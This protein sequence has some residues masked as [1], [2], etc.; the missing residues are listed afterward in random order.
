[1]TDA[2][3]RPRRSS[4]RLTLEDVARAASV[5]P[6]TVSRALRGERS[7]DPVLVERVREAAARLGY[8]PDPA[9]R[10]LASQRSSHVAVLIP[11]LTN[12]LFVD[13]LEA[14]Q[15]TLR[16][17]GFQ[18]LIGVT[19]Y[20]PREE[21]QLLREQLMHRPAGL[22]V[23][24]FERSEETRALIQASRVPCVHVMETSRA[25]GV[26]CVGFS[27]QDAGQA[28]TEHL[29]ARGARRIGYAAA[30]LD[31]RVMQRAEGY[32]RAL[33][34][35][36]CYD[37][38]LEFLRPEP[39]S[40]ALGAQMF[41]R[42]VAEAKPDAIF[43]CNDD[44]AQGALMAA[45]RLG[46]SVPRDVAVAGFNDLPGSDQLLPS[47]T[48]VRTPRREIGQAAAGMLLQLM[49]GTPVEQ[50]CIELAWEVVGRESA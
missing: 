40:F 37:P 3:R 9:A 36:G 48:S 1:M 6:I 33:Q 49:R 22:I 8:V 12:T 28:L 26:H 15:R 44:L 45:P 23:T 10:A 29:L 21:E 38:A 32:R 13:L 18:T 7:V 16:A 47:L 39:S 17:N 41:G 2:T 31:A 5:S 46:I 42:I 24:G 34:A 35:A 25:P 4:G 19:H 11:L 43:F 30:Q 50:S 20:D 14:V 27:Q